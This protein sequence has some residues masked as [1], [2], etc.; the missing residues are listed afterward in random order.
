MQPGRIDGID[1][2][3]LQN[4]IDWTAVYD[5]G[6]RFAT[7]KASEG[8]AYCDPK[9]TESLDGA[10]AAGLIAMS[11][12]F[13]RVSQE[14]PAEQVKRLWDCSGDVM[15]ARVV[16]DLESAPASWGPAQIVDFGEAWV[17]AWSSYS[18]LEPVF[19]SYLAFIKDRMSPAI[20]K[21]TTLAACPLWMAVYKSTTVPWAPTSIQQP[22]LAPPWKTW[23]LWQ[24]SGDGGYRVPGIGVD[25][26]RNLFNGDE[27]ALRAFAGLP[28]LPAP[29]SP[30]EDKI[31]A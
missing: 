29:V 28:E 20:A 7:V 24:Y 8:V 11:Y 9:A 18:I 25:C 16:L 4:P 14:K 30:Y 27:A 23:A 6:F 21:S 19:Y 5:A 31:I 2:S 15:P 10:R 1:V 22:P 12:G 26:D 17:E 3:K 13:A